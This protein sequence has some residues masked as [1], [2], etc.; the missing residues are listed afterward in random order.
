MPEVGQSIRVPPG[1]LRPYFNFKLFTVHDHARSPGEP[2]VGRRRGA[3]AAALAR[4]RHDST[5]VTGGTVT[6]GRSRVGA[7]R[8]SDLK[9]RV[10]PGQHERTPPGSGPRPL[11]LSEPEPVW[12]AACL[13]PRPVRGR[14]VRGEP[15][16]PAPGPGAAHVTAGR[17]EGFYRHSKMPGPFS[18]EH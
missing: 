6:A 3:A 4:G 16:R 12:A 11:R 17:V 2:V 8:Q 10:P 13:R 14:R 5:S 7:F 18:D 9:S 15:E 1:A